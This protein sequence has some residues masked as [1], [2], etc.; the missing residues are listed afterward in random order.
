MRINPKSNEE[1]QSLGLIEPGVYSFEVMNALDTV[2]KSG[3]D[4]IKLQLKVW[5]KSGAER[6]IFD[7]LLDAMAFKL[8]H[9]AE[10][11]GL[12]DKYNHGELLAEDCVHRCGKVEL[13]IE[14][15]S[16]KQDGG[17]YPDKNTV[18]DYV[19]SD[20][21]FV[22]TTQSKIDPAFDDSIPF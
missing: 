21:T 14:K 22:K 1:L 7:Y 6:I 4:M 17:M 11:T 19:V 18:K 13:A 10:S 16:P 15:G 9:F 20:E 12:L 5:D 2:S 8:R 3:N